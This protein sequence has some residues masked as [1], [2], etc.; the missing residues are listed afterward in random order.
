MKARKFTGRDLRFFLLGVATMFLLVMA[1]E[2]KD[3]KRGFEDG[4]RGHYNPSGIEK[5][6]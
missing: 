4:Y 2:W 6:R 5:T 3:F 1:Y